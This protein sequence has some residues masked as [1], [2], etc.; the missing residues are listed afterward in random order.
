[1]VW[2]KK[3]GVNDDDSD[4]GY[5]KFAL[6]V[7]DGEPEVTGDYYSDFLAN[8]KTRL[9][10]LG[11]AGKALEKYEKVLE[12]AIATSK[13]KEEPHRARVRSGGERKK[14]KGDESVATT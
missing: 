9:V 1:M 7:G 12:N 14:G 10:G 11:I 13:Q 6:D 8:L 2:G 5:T 4:E 3:L